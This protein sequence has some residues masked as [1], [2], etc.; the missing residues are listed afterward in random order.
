M[1]KP[2]LFPLLAAALVGGALAG[3]ATGQD[4]PGAGVTSTTTAT[5]VTGVGTASQV[6]GVTTATQVTGTATAGAVGTQPVGAF[7]A[8]AWR[9]PGLERVKWLFR[10]YL[11]R[12]PSLDEVE[13]FVQQAGTPDQSDATMQSLIL[14]GGLAGDFQ[15]AFQKRVD[16]FVNGTEAVYVGDGASAGDQ[17]LGQGLGLTGGKPT[18]RVR[19]RGTQKVSGKKAHQGGL[20]LDDGTTG[21]VPV[22]AT[23]DSGA[24]L[25]G[26]LT[27]LVQ[28]SDD[29]A[30]RCGEATTTTGCFAA[31]LADWIQ[32]G[33]NTPPPQGT[34][35]LALLQAIAAT[36]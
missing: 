35:Y 24:D 3:P 28:A 30:P 34:S 9:G 25:E 33:Q 7:D 32:P 2:P 11:A 14:G 13:A 36:N 6:T 21:D 31:W 29:D 27:P 26:Q 22:Q 23:L 16:G 17:S 15:A 5:Q 1:R 19:H 12:K 8:T 10:V 18:V 4:G 20:G